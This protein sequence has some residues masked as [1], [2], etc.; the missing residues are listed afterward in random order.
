MADV[1]QQLSVEVNEAISG[2]VDMFQQLK[3]ST[4]GCVSKTKID[5]K[6]YRVSDLLPI[7]WEGSNEKGEFRSFMSDLHLWMQAWSNQGVKKTGQR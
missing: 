4:P 3:H 2:R 5:S 6:P 1:I 7:N